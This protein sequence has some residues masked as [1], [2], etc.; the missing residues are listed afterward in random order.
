MEPGNANPHSM[1]LISGCAPFG[2]LKFLKRQSGA[3][4]PGGVARCWGSPHAT[5]YRVPVG[6]RW[7]Y[8][9]RK[10]GVG[11]RKEK[12]GKN[13]EREGEEPYKGRKG[14]VGGRKEKKGKKG[15]REGEEKR[16]R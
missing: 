14:G 12:E 13:G 3:V 2:P 4:A 6:L 8:K 15:E 9:G 10:G 7:P 11:G 1:D 16:G 5:L